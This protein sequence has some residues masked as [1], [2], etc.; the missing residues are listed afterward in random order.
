[1]FKLFEP[2]P[3]VRNTFYIMTQLYIHTHTCITTKQQ[4]HIS[5]LILTTYKVF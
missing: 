3:T 1:M 2:C 5:I 4:I